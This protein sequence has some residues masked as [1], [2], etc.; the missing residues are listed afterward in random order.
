MPSVFTKIKPYLKW[1]ENNLLEVPIDCVWNKWN[2]LVGPCI[3]G[4]YIRTRT[5]KIEEKYGGYCDQKFNE[6]VPC[7]YFKAEGM[8]D[9]I[10]CIWFWNITI[11]TYTSV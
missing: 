5:K 2:D 1:I 4:T 11:S 7:P 6:T 3:N 9:L 8:S 10:H